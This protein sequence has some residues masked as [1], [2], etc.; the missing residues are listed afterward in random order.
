M[1]KAE[2]DNYCDSLPSLDIQVPADDIDISMVLRPVEPVDGVPQYWPFYE[3]DNPEELFG[4]MDFHFG[5]RGGKVKIKL[6]LDLSSVP[7]RDI[8]FALST[9]RKLDGILALSPDFKHQFKT[10]AQ[11]INGRYTELSIVVKDKEHIP[12]NFSFLWLCE[13]VGEGMHFVSG[14]PRIIIIPD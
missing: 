12:D 2:V 10:T 6:T 13:T 3:A 4:N 11:R 8:E 5:G 14:D 9:S 1:N 7:G